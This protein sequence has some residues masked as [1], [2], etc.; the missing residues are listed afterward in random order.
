[1]KVKAKLNIKHHGVWYAPG[2][3]FEAEEADLASLAGL[4]EEVPD[5]TP[6]A[7][8]EKPRAKRTTRKR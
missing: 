4:V 8:E 3:E 2:T 7:A 5:A 1:M 6:T